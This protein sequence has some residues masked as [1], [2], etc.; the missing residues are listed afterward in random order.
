M[1]SCI[2]NSLAI[3]SIACWVGP[4]TVDS[5]ML[6]FPLLF[7]PVATLLFYLLALD[8]R[9]SRWE[10]ILLIGI[11]VTFMLQSLGLGH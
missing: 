9:I 6:D 1:G 4:I 5:R 8:K 3:P 2:F 11:Y 7:L 10:G